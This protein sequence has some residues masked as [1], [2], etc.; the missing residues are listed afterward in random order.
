M[1]PGSQ[2]FRD[3]HPDQ[4][5]LSPAPAAAATAAETKVSSTFVPREGGIKDPWSSLVGASCFT[6]AIPQLA[7][8]LAN[9][10]PY[11]RQET[12]G[13]SPSGV[14]NGGYVSSPPCYSSLRLK[15]L[16]WEPVAGCLCGEP[17]LATRRT[18]CH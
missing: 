4:T 18:H 3:S 10:S 12:E 2:F 7:S 13:G 9:F 17:A 16:W 6:S 15:S 14:L 1:G 5:P 8:C 11:G